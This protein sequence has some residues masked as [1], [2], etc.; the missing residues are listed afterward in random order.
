M[1]PYTDLLRG[2]MPLNAAQRKEARRL[3]EAGLDWPEIAAAIERSVE[4]VQHS[5]AT[6]RT[7]HREPSRGTINA[8]PMA[9]AYLKGR[10]LPGEAMWETVNRL[11]N[12]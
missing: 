11:L 3:R 9:H 10:Q 5:L 1:S 4:D 7:R 6:I 12:L 2:P 8:S